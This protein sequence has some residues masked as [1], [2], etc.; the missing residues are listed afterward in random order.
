MG[1]TDI[2]MAALRIALDN[3]YSRTRKELRK[4]RDEWI[5][6]DPDDFPKEFGWAEAAVQTLSDLE[7]TINSLRCKLLIG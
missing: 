6:T 2:E 4:A 3:Q 5:M 1:L 7:G